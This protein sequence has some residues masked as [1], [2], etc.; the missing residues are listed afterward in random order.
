MRNIIFRAVFLLVTAVVT[1]TP[2]LAR[3]DHAQD[4]IQIT[5][6]KEL[7][8]FSLH[9][10]RLLD[11]KEFAS[12]EEVKHQQQQGFFSVKGLRE[13]LYKCD[14]GEAI[15]SVEITHYQPAHYPGACGLVERFDLL[16]RQNGNAVYEFSSYEG[17][18]CANPDTHFIEMLEPANRYS[19]KDCVIPNGQGQM[20]CV[21]PTGKQSRV[22][23]H[24]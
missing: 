4:E 16:I 2:S 7:N 17:D 8:Y 11:R 20:S 3:A 9:T 13:Q 19:L 14:T 10:F 18:W 15:I 6:S 23:N 22:R 1:F 24:L 5:C 21:Y 12:A